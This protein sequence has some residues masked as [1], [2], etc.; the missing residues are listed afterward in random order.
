LAV[1]FS[2]GRGSCI[3]YLLLVDKKP[4]PNNLYTLHTDTVSLPGTW[5]KK[6]H[7]FFVITRENHEY[8]A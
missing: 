4:L 6:V 3:N 2:V 1:C 5:S 7:L 8:C